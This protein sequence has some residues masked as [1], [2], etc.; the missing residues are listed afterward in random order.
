M[1]EVS[2]TQRAAVLLC[3]CC[4]CESCGILFSICERS[5]NEQIRKNKMAADFLFLCVLKSA[6]AATP[7][8]ATAQRRKMRKN[9]MQQKERKI[10]KK[11]QREATE[12]R[13]RR[14]EGWAKQ[15]HEKC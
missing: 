12:K 15:K 11:K 9:K 5:E 8:D 2:L 1:G 6:P 3:Y 10:Y 14:E 4:C 13:E 7:T